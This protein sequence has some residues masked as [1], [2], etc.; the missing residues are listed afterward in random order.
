MT[1]LVSAFQI[2]ALAVLAS[3]IIDELG[4][5]R[6]QI[7]LIGSIN[8]AV[9]AATAPASG[10]LTD[11]IGPGRSVVILV[12]LGAAGMGLMA[13]APSVAWLWIAAIVGGLAQGWGNPA[14]NAYIAAHIPAGRRGPITGVKQSGVTLGVF[15]SGALLPSMSTAW[16]WRIATGLCAAAFAVSAVAIGAV[17]DRSP[18]AATPS[19]HGEAN[20]HGDRRDGTARTPIPSFVWPLTLFSLLMG[21][22]GGAI[23]RFLP[24]FAE[25]SAGMSV[26]AAGAVVAA[27]GLLG[28][29]ARLIAS[30]QAER[31]GNSDELLIAFALAGVVYCLLL[32]FVTPDTH[33]L[34]YASPPLAAIGIAA[35][36][37][38][39]ML[40]V[41][42]RSPAGGSGRAS[43]IVMLGFLGGLTISGPI[44]GFVVDAGGD[45]NPVWI[46]AAACCAVAAWVIA[47]SRS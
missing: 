30:R 42:T 40:A 36:N 33:W 6:T 37:A 22:A 28:I 26:E 21:I 13:W 25:E 32:L 2:F 5:S 7:G 31:R 11:R 41:I 20:D 34:L 29:A 38:V 39:A 43:G 16:D 17:V 3:A 8:T 45:Y 24:L 18:V 47:R 15:A 46:G 35:W 4:V 19:T 1:M 44:A 27:G 10:R 12:A 14:T 23:G 9:G